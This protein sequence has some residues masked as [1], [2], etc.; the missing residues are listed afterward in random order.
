M[1]M[2]IALRTDNEDSD[3]DDDHDGNDDDDYWGSHYKQIVIKMIAYIF[4]MRMM[5]IALITDGY[6]D[7]DSLTF[8]SLEILV[9]IRISYNSDYR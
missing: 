5:M 9:I 2:M 8:V 3:H 1:L 6:N 4:Q 7:N